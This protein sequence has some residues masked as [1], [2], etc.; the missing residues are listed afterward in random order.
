MV[1][2][3]DR[4]DGLQAEGWG[5][6]RVAEP[7][8]ARSEAPELAVGVDD[9]QDPIGLAGHEGRRPSG[10]MVW[11]GVDAQNRIARADREGYLAGRMSLPSVYERLCPLMMEP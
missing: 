3:L 9:A 8:A 7:M 11:G 5:F 4:V 1:D 6:R 10:G 2:G